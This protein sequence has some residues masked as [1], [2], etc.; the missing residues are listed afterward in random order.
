MALI[1]ILL[2][3]GFSCCTRALY[4]SMTSEGHFYLQP[5]GSQIT[6]ECNFHADEY[7]LFLFPVTWKKQ[8]LTE[9]CQVNVMS[10]INEPFFSTGKMEVSYSSHLSRYR[11]S[12]SIFDLQV[13]DSANYSCEIRDSRAQVLSKITHQ[14]FV[15]APISSLN[16]SIT[17]LNRTHSFLKGISN[18]LY[19]EPVV[20]VED[21]PATISC[22]SKG[23]YP[24]PHLGIQL[25][26]SKTLHSLMST[27]RRL[28]NLTGNECF[29]VIKIASE[30]R[31]HK[32]IPSFKDDEAFVNCSANVPGLSSEVYLFQ[33]SVNFPPKISCQSSGGYVGER[34][35]HLFCEVFSKPRHTDLYWIL[36]PFNHTI[37]RQEK[38]FQEYWA[39]TKEKGKGRLE[40]LLFIRK[41]KGESFRSY[42]LVVENPISLARKSV[43]FYQI[44]VCDK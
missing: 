32:F 33:I 39:V 27:A 5:P 41:V 16:F 24:T 25:N 43:D 28:T 8:Q 9:E 2:M 23:G 20:L 36:D 13:N 4:V 40:A 34:N 3:H 17:S 11:F 7:D 37:I 44:H 35:S 30:I 22:L 1:G 21:V 12:L 29:R 10:S 15:T 6:L 31:V 38:E 19:R 26:R 42:I 18:S 14:V